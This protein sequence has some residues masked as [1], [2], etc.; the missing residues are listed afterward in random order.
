MDPTRGTNA[1]WNRTTNKWEKKA[2]DELLTL[3]YFDPSMEFFSN[4]H[5]IHGY[6]S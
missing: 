1:T 2:A 5:Y 4:T 6:K 3:N